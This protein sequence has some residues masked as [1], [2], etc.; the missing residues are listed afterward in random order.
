MKKITQKTCRG[1]I[2]NEHGGGFGNPAYIPICNLSKKTLPYIVAPSASGRRT[3]ASP[4]DEIPNWCELENDVDSQRLYKALIDIRDEYRALDL[5]YGSKAYAE[6][7]S[8]I[9]DLGL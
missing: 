3:V 4:T 5:P 2:H 8:I 9:N 1:C 7:V 6:I